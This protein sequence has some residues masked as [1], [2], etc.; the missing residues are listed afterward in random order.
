MLAR[1]YLKQHLGVV[2]HVGSRLQ[3]EVSPGKNVR[4]YLKNN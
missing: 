3:S 1:P 4:P 2:V